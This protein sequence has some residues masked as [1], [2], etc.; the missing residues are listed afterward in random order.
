MRSAENLGK[1]RLIVHEHRFRQ[2]SGQPRT[3][4]TPNRRS[5]IQP[6]PLGASLG[7]RFYVFDDPQP[8]FWERL[9][10]SMDALLPYAEERGVRIGFENLY[11]SNHETIKQL[12]AKYSPDQVG[13]CYDTGHGNIAGD[14]LDFL[15]EVK[16]RLLILHLN[17]NDGTGDQHN[18]LFSATV[19]WERAAGIIAASSYE[20]PLSMELSLR[21]SGFEDSGDF[22]ALAMTTGTR[23]AEMVRE[24]RDRDRGE[25]NGL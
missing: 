7:G 17:D 16:E 20:K 3:L 25:E 15:D 22:L 9:R 8:A 18:P 11:P 14:G 5:W 6:R 19:D 4:S 24:G 10:R 23:F 1:P 13:V 12:L 2:R 21:Q